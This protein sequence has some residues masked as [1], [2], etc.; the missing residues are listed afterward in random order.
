[1]R[2][3]RPSHFGISPEEGRATGFHISALQHQ[4]TP[5]R[6]K[7][8]DMSG[9]DNIDDIMQRN[10]NA[11]LAVP[12]DTFAAFAT[13]FADDTTTSEDGSSYSTA[14]YDSTDP[15]ASSYDSSKDFFPNAQPSTDTSTGYDS[16]KD[17]FPN[18]K[19]TVATPAA[20]NAVADAFTSIFTG[21]VKAATPAA[22]AAISNAIN[23]V[24]QGVPATASIFGPTGQQISGVRSAPVTASNMAPLLIAGAVIVGLLMM[25]GGGK[26]G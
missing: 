17:F 1:M 2:F 3:Q 6:M 10:P 22:Q 24:R 23:P 9:M 25:S 16:S 5:W 4:P 13:A 18:A 14:Q 8:P 12:L 21:A 26:K 7:I 20:N 15:S 19:P 11:V